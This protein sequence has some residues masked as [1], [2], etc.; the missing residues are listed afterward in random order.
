MVYGK[1]NWQQG[2]V[3]GFWTMLSIRNSDEDS[4][5]FDMI[6][7]VTL[8]VNIQLAQEMECMEAMWEIFYFKT[9]KP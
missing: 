5:I 8:G 4:S 6:S 2:G 7:N 1:F 9:A 3:G